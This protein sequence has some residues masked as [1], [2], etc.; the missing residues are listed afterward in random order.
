MEAEARK[1]RRD[2][3]KEKFWRGRIREQ[4]G[5]GN[6]PPRP[7]FINKHLYLASLEY[8]SQ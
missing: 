4:G 6:P 1:G 7:E 5:T 3:E 2:P 8:I